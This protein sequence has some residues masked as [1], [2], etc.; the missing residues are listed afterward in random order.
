MAERTLD[1]LVR[2]LRDRRR[3]GEQPPVVLLG[4]GA[5][6]AAGLATM[7]ALYEFTGVAG[8][9]EFVAF[10][11]TRSDN[12]RY[13]LLSDFLQTQ[14]P[15]EVTPGYRA[16]AALCGHAYFDVVLTTNFDPLLD[17]A[18]ATAQLR[19]KDYLLLINGVLRPDR[20]RWLLSSRSPRVKVVKLH[21]DLFHRFM[22]WTPAE[23]DAYL[24]DVGPALSTF[25]ATRD[26]LVVGHSLRD[27]RIA[28]LVTGAGGAI[29]FVNLSPAPDALQADHDLRSVVGEGMGFE[30]VFTTLAE[31]LGAAEA[32]GRRTKPKPSGGRRTGRT[33]VAGFGAAASLDAGAEPGGAAAPPA[34]AAGSV[35]V[36]AAQPDAAA[37]T[38]DPAAA[39][40]GIAFTPDGAP[41]ATGFLLAEPRVIVTDG[42]LAGIRGVDPERIT[43]VT[44]SGRRIATRALR[45]ATRHP[46]GP[47]ILAAPPGLTARGLRV[48]ATPLKKGDAVQIAVA[49]GERTGL[50]PATVVSGRAVTLQVDPMGTVPDL[51]HVCAH[52]APG[53][54]GAPA[55]DDELAV[56]GFVAAG[57][58][59]EAHPDT[60]LYL[61]GRW[62]GG[63]L[64][65]AP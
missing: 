53:C 48:D 37:T 54:S 51:V 35:E 7:K 5:S 47:W 58:T 55:V 26:F 31:R 40:V 33:T 42:Y 56:R 1:E 22:A 2:D 57:S 32:P 60:Y 44:A 62:L 23:M 30:Q 45:L 17:D 15:H 41:A 63:V 36:A 13:R 27:E 4:A 65:T 28:E 21:G 9:D 3:L 64:T 10:L 43:L 14:D 49:A 50:A 18:L 38:D 39:T 25:L 6:A 61:A 34:P 46:S 12:E 24:Q 52:L 11:E 19:R 20:L 8:F 29:W 59:D 16:L